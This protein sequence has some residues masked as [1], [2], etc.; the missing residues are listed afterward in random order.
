MPPDPEIVVHA[1]LP[2]PPSHEGVTYDP[3]DKPRQRGAQQTLPP[4][5]YHV[6][7][8]EPQELLDPAARARLA[9]DIS[10]AGA[11]SIEVVLAYSTG[12]G[13]DLIHGLRQLGAES[14]AARI[15]V[16]AASD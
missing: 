5:P 2:A 12:V 14:G 4:D 8:H 15:D 7:L 13:P 3:E 16:H 9:G 1:P 10:A 11:N 6:M